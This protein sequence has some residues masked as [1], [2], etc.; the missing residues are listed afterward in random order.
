MNL[1]H[2]TKVKAK[3]LSCF[4]QQYFDKTTFYFSIYSFN[5]ILIFKWFYDRLILFSHM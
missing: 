1:L 4:I 3:S 5:S 2:E